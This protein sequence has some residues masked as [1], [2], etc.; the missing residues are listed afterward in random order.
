MSAGTSSGLT[1]GGVIAT[2]EAAFLGRLERDRHSDPGTQEAH[3]LREAVARL[4][5][6]ARPD[7]LDPWGVPG[8]LLQREISA[9]ESHSGGGRIR[10]AASLT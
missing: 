6:R 1:N 10:L 5:E 3:T 9:W 7:S 8:R 4:A 2:S